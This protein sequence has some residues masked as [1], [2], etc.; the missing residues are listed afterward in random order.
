MSKSFSLKPIKVPFV[1]TKNRVIKTEIPTPGDVE[2]IE[3][4]RKYEPISMTGQPPV[5]WDRAIGINV[6]DRWGNKWLDFSSGVVVANAGHSNPKVQDAVR[7]IVNHGMMHSYCFPNLVRAKLVKVISELVPIPDNRVFLLTTGGESTECA[8][9]LSRT[10][11]KSKKGDKKITIVGFDDSFHGRT[12]GAQLVGGGQKGKAWITNLDPN[13]VHVPF[14]NAFKYEWADEKRP[15]YSDEKCFNHFLASLQNQGVDYDSIAGIM[16]E[17]FQG[18]WVQLMPKGFLKLLREFCDKHDILLIFDE[19]QAGFGRTGKLFGF[20]HSDIIPDLIC[21][22]KGITS[23]MPLSSVI[24]RRDVMDLYGP[25]EMTS[26]HSGNPVCS[27][28]ALA[29]IQQI[30][31]EDLVGNANKLQDVCHDRLTA[32]QQKYPDYIG[33]VSG[34]GLVWAI[35]FIKP[36]TKDY[37]MDLA[38]DIVERS[39]QKGLMFFAPVGSGSTIKVCPPLIINQEALVEGL[40]VFEEAVS[41]AIRNL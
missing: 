12:M 8:I 31:E 2:I 35:I 41:E 36:G 34:Y 20:M 15:D 14:P 9:K 4:M 18:G 29:S 11:G 7:E 13:I 3:Q 17:T 19:V 28:A 39:M 27:A 1:N 10:Y 26:T 6:F 25:N 22:G 33:F 30:L 24:G 40:D 37:N 38:H 21:C 32:L 16:T 5:V 23:G